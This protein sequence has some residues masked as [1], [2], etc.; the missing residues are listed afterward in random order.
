MATTNTQDGAR[1]AAVAGGRQ[2]TA[3]PPLPKLRFLPKPLKRRLGA[4]VSN[5]LVRD[6]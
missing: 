3:E 2:V 6:A 1:T 5:R 4:W